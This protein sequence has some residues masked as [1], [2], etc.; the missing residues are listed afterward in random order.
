VRNSST[1]SGRVTID[2][3]DP[4]IDAGPGGNNDSVAAAPHPHG[5]FI[6][7]DWKSFDAGAGSDIFGRILSKTSFLTIP[8]SGKHSERKLLKRLCYIKANRVENIIFVFC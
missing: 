3:F 2:W 6:V 4:C 7:Y 1:D 5:F 8:I